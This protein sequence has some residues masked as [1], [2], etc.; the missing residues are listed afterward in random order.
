MRAIFD[1]NVMTP[2]S[3]HLDERNHVERPFLDQLD[4][5]GWEILD[6]D[7]EQIPAD[8]HREKFAEVVMLPVLRERLQIIN[9]WL[10]NDQ[11]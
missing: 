3:H 4:G 8:S 7:K 5:L 2:R 11:I 6:L 10:E 9:P 1:T